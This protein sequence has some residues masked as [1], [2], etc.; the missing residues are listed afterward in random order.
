MYLKMGLAAF[1]LHMVSAPSL[2]ACRHPV[3]SPGAVRTRDLAT[4]KLAQSSPAVLY[5]HR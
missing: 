5:G 1:P 2:I 3:A 4:A